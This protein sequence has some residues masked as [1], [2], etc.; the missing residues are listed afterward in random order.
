MWSDTKLGVFLLGSLLI[1]M[2]AGAAPAARSA[3]TGAHKVTVPLH[4]EEHRPYAE[5][6]LTGPSGKP[7]RALFWLDTG[8]G[9][10]ILS[11]P[12]A[13]RLGLKASAKTFKTEG[14]VISPTE[15]PQIRIAGMALQLKQANAFLV[16]G[17]KPT[18]EGTGAEGAFPVRALRKYQVVLDYPHARLTIAEPG[19]LRPEGR[20]MVA[21]F[22]QKNG[23]IAVSAKIGGRPYGFLL[24][25]GAQYCMVSQV[26]LAAWQKQHPHWANVTGAYG[27]ANMMVGPR[28]AS[29]RMLRIGVLKWGS[30]TLR[31]I[32]TVSRPT[33]NY[34]R[35]MSRLTGRPV[36]GSIGG[37]VLRH[38]R[39][40]IE[41]PDGRLYLKREGAGGGT[42]LD[43]VGITLE[44][45]G[46]GYVVVG[47][48][49]NEIA[50]K[51]GDELL[52]IG[53]APINGLTIA[54]IMHKLAGNPGAIRKLTIERN[55]RTLRVTARVIRIY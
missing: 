2:S 16:V 26:E 41:Y 51:K 30:F 43:M 48:A 37:N 25:S 46:R 12:L 21:H 27:P 36:I 31:N 44:P 47:V 4:F 39:V 50:L 20:R 32:G 18:L 9:A 40:D 28:E 53:D 52:G 5:L 8:G 17:K 11:G 10:V 1:P 7:V 6:T 15:V 22:S 23:F 14:N 45:S 35:M 49:K 13:A 24:D 34:E 33:G 3:H 29:F 42:P 55:H 54:E 19:T 38:F